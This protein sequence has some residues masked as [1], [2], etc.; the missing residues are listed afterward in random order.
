MKLFTS[1]K[2]KDATMRAL[3]IKQEKKAGNLTGQKEGEYE[4]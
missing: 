3:S 1:Q 2:K 4:N